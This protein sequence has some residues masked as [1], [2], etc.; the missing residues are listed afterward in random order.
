MV[1][2][3]QRE[4]EVAISRGTYDPA[5]GEPFAKGETGTLDLGAL[6]TRVAVP[7][8][9][10]RGAESDVLSAETAADMARRPEVELVELPGI[11]HAPA[12]MEPSQIERIAE[13]L[14]RR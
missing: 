3:V 6:W 14:G 5:I 8:L 7:V 11:G 13:F 4:P 12:L 9:L 1:V 10:L 2:E